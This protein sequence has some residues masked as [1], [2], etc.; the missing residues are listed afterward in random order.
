M[1]NLRF[2]PEYNPNFL[3]CGKGLSIKDVCSQEE[4]VRCGYFANKGRGALDADVFGAK[5]FGF[6]EIYGV[7]SQ[8]GHFVDN[9]EKGQFIA[10]FLRTSFMDGP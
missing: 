3:Y 2:M 9:G 4:V 5:N 10:F 8:C 7:L 6:F 1:A